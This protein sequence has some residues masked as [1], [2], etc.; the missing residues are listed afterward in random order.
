[1]LW[2]VA[3]AAGF[4]CGFVFFVGVVPE[5]LWV[6]NFVFVVAYWLRSL[7]VVFICIRFGLV[8]VYL[9]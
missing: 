5:P 1:M 9:F 2:F 4:T 6:W 7:V 3:F 8:L